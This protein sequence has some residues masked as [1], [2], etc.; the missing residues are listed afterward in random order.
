MVIENNNENGIFEQLLN[1]YSRASKPLLALC[2]LQLSIF[3]ILKIVKCSK[4]LEQNI[5]PG[6]I[7]DF[8][9][10]DILL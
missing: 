5:I 6:I 10:A 8:P 4:I 2:K 7:N 9:P 3:R 1:H